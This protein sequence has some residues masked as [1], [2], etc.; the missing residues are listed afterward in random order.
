LN[1]FTAVDISQITDTVLAAHDV[2]ILGEVGLTP[3]Q[4]TMFT[5]WV[6]NGGNLI[7]MRPDKKLAPCGSD[8]CRD[9]AVGRVLVGEDGN[10]ARCRHRHGLHLDLRHRVVVGN[11]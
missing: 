3:T 10:R 2:V 9:D 5:N 8:R 7:A 6:N 4:V 11:E 1:A